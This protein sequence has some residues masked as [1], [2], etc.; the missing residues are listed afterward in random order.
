MRKFFMTQSGKLFLLSEAQS[1]NALVTTTPQFGND[2]QHC[3]HAQVFPDN[4]S[5]TIFFRQFFA[6]IVKFYNAIQLYKF[7]IF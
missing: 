6:A 1:N 5:Q 7:T 3:A 2:R 4:F